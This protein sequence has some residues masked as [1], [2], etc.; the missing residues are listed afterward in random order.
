MR[1]VVPAAVPACS[2]TS[3]IF[4]PANIR[5]DEHVFPWPNNYTGPEAVP[6]TA[7]S[8]VRGPNLY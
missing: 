4:E 2:N 3:D 7:E 5:L 6:V 1:K 8:A